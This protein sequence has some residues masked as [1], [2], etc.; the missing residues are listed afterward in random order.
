MRIT[1]P[2]WEVMMLKFYGARS[3]KGY[4]GML[5]R[6]P[7]AMT[8]QNNALIRMGGTKTLGRLLGFNPLMVLALPF[9]GYA[10]LSY[11]MLALRG[12]S[13]P[14]VLCRPF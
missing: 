6:T 10:Y 4:V 12:S 13:L 11:T 3:E 7:K 9:I 8:T 5:R 14:R 2:F 1:P